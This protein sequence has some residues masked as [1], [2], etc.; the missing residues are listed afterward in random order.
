M[1]KRC[2]LLVIVFL[3][4]LSFPVK[5]AVLFFPYFNSAV[6]NVF[7]GIDEVENEVEVTVTEKVAIGALQK[8]EPV[9]EVIELPEVPLVIIQKD[10][11]SPSELMIQKGQTV[12]WTN[13]REKLTA[14]VLGLREVQAMKSGSLKPGES[15]Q[16]TFEESG[17][18]T[19]VDGVVIGL[20]GK[21]VVE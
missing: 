16:W 14:I 3:L 19:Y 7:G 21:V 8:E 4:V 20:V 6:L 5:G 12:Q 9:I 17:E 18:F 10:S 1:N 2:V 13:Q 15:F 11:F